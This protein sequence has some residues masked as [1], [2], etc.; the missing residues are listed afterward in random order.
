MLCIGGVLLPAGSPARSRQPGRLHRLFSISTPLGY[1]S[2]RGSPMFCNAQIGARELHS[3]CQPDAAG[4]R[5]LEVAI[6]RLGLSARAYTR[7]LKVSRTLAD[8]DGE[9]PK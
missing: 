5:L 8:L 7:I 4:E 9:G 3:Y 6:N 2:F 1:T